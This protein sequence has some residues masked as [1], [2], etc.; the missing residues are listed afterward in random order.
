MTHDIKIISITQ[1]DW[2]EIATIYQQGID[3]GIATFED[4]V[5]TWKQWNDSHIKSC[6]YKAV[7]S[8]ITVGWVALSNVSKRKVYAGVAE[9]SI[10]IEKEHRNK[11]IGKLLLESAIK[12]SENNGFWTLQAGIFSDNKASIALHK[13]MGFRT[14]GVR[15]KIAKKDK[16]WYDNVILERRSKIII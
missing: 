3:T 10:Y 2:P 13:T 6:R 15:K 11:G 4:K 5:P 8:N 7:S 12:E 16:T 9:V 1:E 14:V